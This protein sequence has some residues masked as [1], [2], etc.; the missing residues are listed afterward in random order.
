MIVQVNHAWH[1]NAPKDTRVG[2]ILLLPPAPR[3]IGNWTGEVTDVG[4]KYLGSYEGSIKAAVM[5]LSQQPLGE[6][7]RVAALERRVSHLE[8]R[9]IW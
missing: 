1:Y 4:T 3:K 5:N 8:R 7:D 6:P 2:D 9:R